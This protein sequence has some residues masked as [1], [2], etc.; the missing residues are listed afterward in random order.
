MLNTLQ[1]SEHKC[2]TNFSWLLKYIL[3]NEC[4][5][6]K[7]S[8]MYDILL[9]LCSLIICISTISCRVALY[10]CNYVAN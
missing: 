4:V 10:I 7:C 6:Y 1:L 9:A 3:I 8:Y 5:F 2:I